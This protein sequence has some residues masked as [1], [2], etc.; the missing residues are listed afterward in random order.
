MRNK[1]FFVALFDKLNRSK[2]LFG[3][4]YCNNYCV[5]NKFVKIFFLLQI[6]QFSG[7][8]GTSDKTVAVCHS[9]AIF[10]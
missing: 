3:F 8:V 7:F 5:T 6:L 1:D 2:T 4:L 10:S 9:T